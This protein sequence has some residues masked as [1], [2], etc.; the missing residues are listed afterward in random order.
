MYRPFCPTV[1]A[2]SFFPVASTNSCNV[3]G[4]FPSSLLKKLKLLWKLRADAELWRQIPEKMAG[5]CKV[6]RHLTSETNVF[7]LKINRGG[8][9]MLRRGTCCFPTKFKTELRWKEFKYCLPQFVFILRIP[10]CMAEG[11]LRNRRLGKSTFIHFFFS[12][13]D[14]CHILHECDKPH[15]FLPSLL[16]SLLN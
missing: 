15:L 14:L 1:T 9:L 12:L 6:E 7:T 13:S 4:L 11:S 8:P 3:S 2:V 5:L 10:P 16:F